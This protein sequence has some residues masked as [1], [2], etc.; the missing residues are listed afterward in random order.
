MPIWKFPNKNDLD[1]VWSIL[2]FMDCK[3]Y[4]HR[5]FKRL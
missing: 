3:F 5:C 4:I 2:S 1:D